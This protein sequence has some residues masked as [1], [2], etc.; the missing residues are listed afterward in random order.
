MDTKEPLECQIPESVLGFGRKNANIAGWPF[1]FQNVD[2][3]S[4]SVSFLQAGTM[5]GVGGVHNLFPRTV[6][7]WLCVTLCGNLFDP[8]SLIWE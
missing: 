3:E 1:L 6:C 2:R 8:L 4:D 7:G 5:M